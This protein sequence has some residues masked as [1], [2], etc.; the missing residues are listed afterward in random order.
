[1]R[2]PFDPERHFGHLLETYDAALQAA[3]DVASRRPGPQ[4]EL[5]ALHRLRAGLREAAG[6]H[7]ATAAPRRR[8]KRA[9]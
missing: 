3:V 1:M 4:H 5:H 7:L 6:R 2:V 9:T 8:R